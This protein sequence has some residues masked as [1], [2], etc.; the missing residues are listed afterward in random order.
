VGHPVGLEAVQVF[1]GRISALHTTVDN[2][3]FMMFDMTACG[4]N[5]GSAVVDSS[6]QVTECAADWVRSA[7]QWV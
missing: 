4:G 7:V 6:D 5:S 3:S 2:E 1:A